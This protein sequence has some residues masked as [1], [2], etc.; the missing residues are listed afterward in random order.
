[1]IATLMGPQIHCPSIGTFEHVHNMRY[2]RARV[3]E[4]MNVFKYVGSLMDLH[5]LA[6][7]HLKSGE[8]R[9]VGLIDLSLISTM[10]IDTQE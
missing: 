1:M 3:K 6:T 7:W 4:N 10:F 8:T 5:D 9:S 2:T